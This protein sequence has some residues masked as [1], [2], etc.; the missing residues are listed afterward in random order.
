MMTS[1]F[2]K[3]LAEVYD[4]DE[5]IKQ[6]ELQTKKY[7]SKIRLGRT[8][9]MLLLA[10]T[11]LL[12]S[13]TTYVLLRKREQINFE[14][15]YNQFSRTLGDAAISEMKRLREAVRSFG[16]VVEVITKE[17]NQSW[18]FFDYAGI[19]MFAQEQLD[20]KGL[21]N[22]QYLTRVN[23]SQREQ[24]LAFESDIYERW[25]KSGHTRAYG[26]LDSLVE[27]GYQADILEV[28]DAGVYPSS[29]KEEYWPLAFRYPPPNSYFIVGLDISSINYDDM[30]ASLKLLGNQTLI[31][32]VNPYI[33]SDEE[34]AK[35]HAKFHSTLADGSSRTDFPHSFMFHPVHQEPNNSSSDIVAMVLVPIA[36]DASLRNLLPASVNGLVV[37]GRNS[38]GQEFSYLIE[39]EN[40]YFIGNE[41]LHDEAYDSM[42]TAVNLDFSV[43]PKFGDTAGHCTYTLVS[44]SIPC[45]PRGLIFPSF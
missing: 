13:A 40:A 1:S 41:D 18:P 17:T 23:H 14:N 16:Q 5:E 7:T 9:V 4:H 8:I 44:L 10:V 19:E 12:V 42:E 32:N 39:G 26:N 33:E 27:G 11:G 29:E 15:A 34:E 28:T 20:S 30:F 35:Q 22:L 37:V 31:S 38:C 3:K 21:E 25:V 45:V 24:W 6:V 2:S 36:W 43:H